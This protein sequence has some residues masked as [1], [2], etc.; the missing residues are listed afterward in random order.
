MINIAGAGA[1]VQ[2]APSASINAVGDTFEVNGAALTA[3]TLSLTSLRGSV[4]PSVLNQAVTFT[5]AVRPAIAGSGTPGGSVSFVDTT[6]GL[7]LGTAPL[8]SGV[9][10]LTA[11]SLGISDHVISARYG[12]DST[13]AFSLDRL[14]QTVL[15]HFSGF[16][17]PLST[18]LSY[19]AGR[20]IPIKFQLTDY[21][22]APVTT[23]SAVTSLQFAPVHADGSL[24]TPFNPTG[25]GG[26][27]LRYD[28]SANQFV[29]NWSTKGLATGSYAILLSLADG[30]IDTKTL[31]LTTSSGASG[32]TTGTNGGTGSAPGGLL[33]G[34]IALYVDNSNANLTD[35]ELA[36]IQDAVATV[37]A[38]VQ[39][40]GV[41]VAEVTDPTLADVTLNMDTTSAV[42]GYAVGVLGCTTEAGHITIITG[43]NFYGGSDPTQVGAGQYDFETVVIHELGHA[44]GL[45]HSADPTSVMYATLAAGVADR[46]MTTAD[47]NVPDS[48]NGAC[49]LHAA[50]ARTVTTHTASRVPLGTVATAVDIGRA[51]MALGDLAARNVASNHWPALPAGPAKRQP[52]DRS[53]LRGPDPVGRRVASLALGEARSPVLRAKIVDLVLDGLVRRTR[54]RS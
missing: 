1:L 50:A 31:Q 13:F 52:A 29:F 48:D 46:V 30:T 53:T 12:G 3:S 20:T 2:A 34:D 36:R 22:G 28:S 15:Y 43:W 49:G 17:A 23:L 4:D 27:N 11:S 33:G 41:T 16:L 26:T 8:V 45:G 10:T 19:G 39:P 6:T 38:L 7:T 18:G 25:S 35:D 21:H 51:W 14:T 54:L 32:L 5:A 40:Y 44:L 9:A 42:G 37:D 24:G 47:L